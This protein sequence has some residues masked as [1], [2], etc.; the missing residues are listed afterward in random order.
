MNS[1]LISIGLSV[2]IFLYAM[3][4]TKARQADSELSKASSIEQRVEH[5]V[6]RLETV[7]LPPH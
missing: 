6:A 5:F 3:P 7:L 1:A 2:L 4:Q